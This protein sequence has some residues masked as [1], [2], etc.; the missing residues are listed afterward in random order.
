M[1]YYLAVERTPGLY[2]AVNIKKTTKGKNLFPQDDKYECTLDE[3]DKFTTEYE[4]IKNL[5]YMLNAEHKI[6]W[7]NSALSLVYVNEHE[8]QISQDILFKSSKKYLKNPDL[9]VAYITHNFLNYDLDF[10]K[11][12]ILKE[13]EESPLRTKL[14]KL[15]KQIETALIDD[16][17]LDV[18]CVTNIAKSLIYN[19]DENNL[20][21]NSQ[22][23]DYLKLHNIIA[24]IIDYEERKTKQK[25]KTKTKNT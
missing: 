6:P 11:E 17:L 10:V 2:E 20:I 18:V 15:Y 8:L 25:T 1:A 4:N 23:I 22:S 5:K 3:I 9:V 7:A 12:L 13:P 14:E 21:I 19:L 24:F 16:F